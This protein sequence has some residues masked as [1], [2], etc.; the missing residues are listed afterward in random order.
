MEKY[1]NL[2]DADF[3]IRCKIYFGLSEGKY[4]DAGPDSPPLTDAFRRVIVF[5]HGFA[6]HKDNHAAELLA[7]RILEKHTDTALVIFN[8]PAHGDD[9]HEF[10][11]LGDCDRYLDTMIKFVQDTY[12]PKI[13]EAC[14]TSFGAY[15]LL[16]Y[17]SEHGSNPFY[18]ICLRCPAIVMYYVLT[19]VILPPEDL[20][21]LAEGGNVSSGFDRLVV[22]TPDFVQELKKEDIR[23]RDFRKYADRIRIVQ[24]TADELVPYREVAAFAEKNG[25]GIRLVKDADH[26]F[27]DPRKMDIVID[28][29]M[30]FLQV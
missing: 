17:L 28:T 1:F 14:A 21:T 6:G 10:L 7:G 29:F 18:R 30:D 27:L 16:K 12:H 22:I 19:G 8:W 13:L 20:K 25:I 23:Q 3:P 2:S 26:R 11:D 4:E 5:C 9:K 24:G 15:L